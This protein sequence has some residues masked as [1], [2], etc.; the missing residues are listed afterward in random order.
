MLVSVID[1][2]SLLMLITDLMTRKETEL[3]NVL[4]LGCWPIK[5]TMQYY[6]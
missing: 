6:Y 4:M 3:T 1:D 2:W 5:N